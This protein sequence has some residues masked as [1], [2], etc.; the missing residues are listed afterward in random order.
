MK[1]PITL[2]IAL[3]A[4]LALSGPMSSPTSAA[5]SE[6]QLAALDPTLPGR[7]ACRGFF[8]GAAALDRRLE[9]ARSFGASQLA[10][11]ATI[12]LIGNTGRYDIP[13]TELTGE[14]R[15]YFDQGIALTYGF[16]HKAAIRSFREAARLAPDCAM[17]WWGVALANGPNINA[18]M[19]DAANR[20]ALAALERATELAANASE[21]ERAI[22]AAQTQR[23]SFDADRAA[24]DAQYADAMAALADAN[25]DND[26]L[27][28]LAAEAAMNTTPW[29]YWTEGKK[30]QPRIGKAVERIETV[31]ARNP[32][33]PQASHLLIHLLE[34]GPDPKQAEAAADELNRS[35]PRALGHLVHM[36]AHIYYRIGRYGDSIEANIAAA[37][38]DQAYL[39]SAPE[40][41]LY[42]YGY[43]P[44]NVHFL[45]TSAQMVGN[46]RAVASETARLE[47]ILDADIARQLAWVQA[48]HAAPHFALA[49]TGS[50]QAILALTNEKSDLAYVDAMR[51]Y[52]RAVGHALAGDETSAEEVIGQIDAMIEA[53]DVQAMTGQGFP[54]PDIVKLAG[55]AAR[56]RL[57][58]ASGDPAAAVR[59]F[60]LA[61]SIEATIPYSEP[62]FWYYP[63]AQSRGAAL[64]KMGRHE[65]AVA[66]F[67]KALFQAPN[68]GWALYGLSKAQ[69]AAGNRMEARAAKAKLDE[70]W[71][72]ETEWLSM[73]RL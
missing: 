42:R 24:L 71:Q 62:P 65:E 14:A 60:E 19:D 57:A 50:P 26:D 69:A 73:D 31:L 2:G 46:M 7:N 37:R 5:L 58:L 21:T 3:A 63:V 41:A 43:Y 35:G 12:G 30:A 29:N 59:Y 44:H 23:Y 28:I 1:T 49:Q 64:Y 10:T 20:D 27:Q 22:I 52:A 18:G 36:P 61:E 33:H 72:G 45:L 25:A 53:P 6:A 55:L 54:A 51:L 15:S 17:C 48:I 68:N 56:G 32:Q 70:I 16:N 34:N 13:A 67:R 11:G 47:G 38:A 8:T 40:D 66:A 9:L 39:A 4:P